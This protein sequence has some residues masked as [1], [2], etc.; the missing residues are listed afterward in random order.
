MNHNPHAQK[1]MQQRGI[2]EDVINFILSYGKRVRRPGGAIGYILT[3]KK[4]NDLITR[5]KKYMR[6]L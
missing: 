5:I 6:K 1:R 2:P 3:K 4:C